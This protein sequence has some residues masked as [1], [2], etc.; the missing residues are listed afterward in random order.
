MH[1]AA[2]EPASS[3]RT[4]FCDQRRERQRER[5]HSSPLFRSHWKRPAQASQT[6]A[7]K[8]TSSKR[9]TR[10][11]TRRANGPQM[12]ESDGNERG[13]DRRENEGDQLA[14]LQ[15]SVTVR[16]PEH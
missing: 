16:A 7:T 9:R 5:E 12:P 3:G 6:D 15:S 4:A 13:R 11:T 2:R 10:P 14:N 8:R 1:R